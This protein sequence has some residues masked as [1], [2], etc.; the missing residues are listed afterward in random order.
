LPWLSHLHWNVARVHAR[1]CIV[2]I[3]QASAAEQNRIAASCIEVGSSV[4][5]SIAWLADEL[6]AVIVIIIKLVIGI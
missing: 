4:V 2:E 5:E 3:D 6:P 1:G